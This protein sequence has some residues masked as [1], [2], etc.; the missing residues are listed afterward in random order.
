MKNDIRSTTIE[1]RLIKLTNSDSAIVVD[2]FRRVR[3][4]I[5]PVLGTCRFLSC[6]F[7]QLRFRQPLFRACRLY[8]MI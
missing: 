2:H 4:V 7:H 6:Q 5:E 8:D 3:H 1:K